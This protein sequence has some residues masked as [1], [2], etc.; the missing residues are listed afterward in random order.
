MS[1]R[2]P[3]Q[4][5]T[6]VVPY[7]ARCATV[8]EG[9]TGT[10]RRRE[11]AGLLPRSTRNGIF[12]GGLA[13]GGTGGDDI[14]VCKYLESR[15]SCYSRCFCL[16]QGATFLP[17]CEPNSNRGKR[18]QNNEACFYREMTWFSERGVDGAK[19]LWIE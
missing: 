18:V 8:L 9:S 6:R 14:A 15:S 1:S 19:L 16:N 17:S 7:L 13:M 10:K 4:K 12:D 3:E 5:R 2:S 11:D